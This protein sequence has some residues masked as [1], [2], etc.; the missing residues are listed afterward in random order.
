MTKPKILKDITGTNHISDVLREEAII[1]VK[2]IDKQTKDGM[3]YN[4][5]SIEEKI[6]GLCATREW[7]IHFFNITDED[8]K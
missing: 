8:L 4:F 5:N 3:L 7:I 6:N 1:W 2:N